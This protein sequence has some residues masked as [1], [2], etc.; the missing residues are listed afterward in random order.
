MMPALVHFRPSELLS[1]TIYCP[2][3]PESNLIV[4]RVRNDAK[5]HVRKWTT[6]A[7]VRASIGLRRPKTFGGSDGDSP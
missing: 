7:A 5:G 4:A 6:C 3:C 1:P 2:H